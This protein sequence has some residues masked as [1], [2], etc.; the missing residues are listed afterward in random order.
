MV[1]SNQL[2]HETPRWHTILTDLQKAANESIKA[3]NEV[4]NPVLDPILLTSTKEYLQK[5]FPTWLADDGID[6]YRLIEVL[7]VKL[8][9]LLILMLQLVKKL[10]R[11]LL[12]LMNLFNLMNYVVT[13]LSFYVN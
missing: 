8:F 1:S 10:F 13:T 2:A 5:S 3:I 4:D 12:L 9:L 6:L 11:S 7:P